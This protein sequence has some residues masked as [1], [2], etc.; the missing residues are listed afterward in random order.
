MDRILLISRDG[1]T[2]HFETFDRVISRT[3][4]P[5][6]VVS[7]MFWAG[8]VWA[9]EPT[10]PTQQSSEAPASAQEVT[11][12]N[13]AAT[14]VEPPPLVRWEDYQGP[15]KKTVG[16]FARK[17]ERKSVITPHYKPGA[18]LCSLD[19]KDKFVLFVQDTFD[20][21][22]FLGAGFNAGLDQAEDTDPSFGQGAAGYGKRFG[23]EFV[24]QASSGFFKDFA[25]P[26]IF[27]E[28]PRYYRLAHGPSATR[29]L[30]AAEHVVVAHRENGRHIFNFSEWLG[31]ASAVA[32]ADLYHPDNKPGFAPAA[33][34]VGYAFAQDFGFDVLREFWPEIARKFRLP[35][36]DQEEPQNPASGPRSSK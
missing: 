15:L 21:V 29:F 5:M 4:T 24:D 22:T 31:T 13:P 12:K 10:V 36:R 32:L 3:L 28:D 6:A 11:Q 14:C 23:G 27:R 35:F 26:T 19:L 30:H 20:P 25:F 18:V 1:A 9:Q 17:L 34:Q 16:T 7:L 33:R 8:A 2:A